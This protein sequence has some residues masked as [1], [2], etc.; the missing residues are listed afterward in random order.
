MAKVIVMLETSENPFK[1]V[2]EE[3]EKMLVIIAKE[4][5]ADKEQNAWCIDER[6]TN[7]DEKTRQ[8]NIKN[9]LE[10][11]IS[12]LNEE[13]DNPETGLKA[14]IS[15]LETS[16]AENDKAQ[17]SE[18]EQRTEDNKAYQKDIANLV[19]AEEL[20]DKAIKV[21]TAYYSQ[22][23]GAFLQKGRDGPAPPDT[24][25]EGAYE[26]RSTEGTGAIEMLTFILSETKKEE[27][28]AHDDE[29]SAQ[30]DFEDSMEA[31]TTE[32]NNLRKSLANDQ[33]LLAEKEEELMTRKKE[34]K[35]A[36]EEIAAIK[37][38]LRKIKPGCDFITENLTMRNEARADETKALKKAVELIKATPAYQIAENDKHQE[39]LGDCKEICNEEGEEHVKCKACLAETSVPGYC[40]G[41]AGT[42]GC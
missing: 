7:N 14:S 24:W 18:T 25:K 17:K 27:M 9:G 21:L 16:L 1:T 42:V 31:L 10:A 34:L 12:K 6:K 30:H 11:D 41:H 3:I 29:K 23:E 36:K 26:G 15:S 2:L 37:A 19:A 4:E 28:T 33:E 35:A 8:T 20:L 5:K 13:I 39:S 38:Y 22:L 40:A 32:E